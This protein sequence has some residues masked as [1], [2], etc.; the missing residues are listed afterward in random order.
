MNIEWLQRYHWL[1]VS[2][3]FL[4]PLWG[5]ATIYLSIFN[6]A[7]WG[8]WWVYLI[9]VLCLFLTIISLRLGFDGYHVD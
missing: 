9:S 4:Y 1:C 7:W 2:V 8:L 5:L 6:F 3:A